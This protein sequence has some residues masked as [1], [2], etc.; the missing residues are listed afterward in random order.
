MKHTNNIPLISQLGA[1][2]KEYLLFHHPCLVHINSNV[3][4]VGGEVVDTFELQPN[5]NFHIDDFITWVNLTSINHRLV[6]GTGIND[7]QWGRQFKSNEEGPLALTGYDRRYSHQFTRRGQI[8]YYC[9]V[10]PRTVGM[11]EIQ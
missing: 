3:P 4:M 7:H 5:V 6:S 2:R 11:I 9:T 10:H 1:L 8:S